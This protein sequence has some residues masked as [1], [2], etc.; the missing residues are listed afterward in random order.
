[1]E[2]A[3]EHAG[4]A[5][6]VHCRRDESPLERL[7]LL[8]SGRRLKAA[9][10]STGMIAIH[11]LKPLNRKAVLRAAGRSIIL[12]TTEERNVLGGLGS[13]V[14]EVLTD[15]GCGIRL[16]R[17]GIQNECSLIASPTHLYAHY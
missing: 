15:E 3:V 17:H 13:A 16:I 5:R 6:I 7:E 11:T 8:R 2:I 14:A 10:R 4:A 1:M 12:M 9:G